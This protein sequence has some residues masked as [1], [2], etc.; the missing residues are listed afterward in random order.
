MLGVWSVFVIFIVPLMAQALAGFAPVVHAVSDSGAL[1]R[2]VMEAGA[3]VAAA[4]FGVGGGLVMH[5]RPPASGWPPR[6]QPQQWR[7]GLPHKGRPPAEQ[8]CRSLAPVQQPMPT[9][10]HPSI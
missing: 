10:F 7:G 3:A 9:P 6:Q 5:G 2:V 1:Q 4:A 8:S